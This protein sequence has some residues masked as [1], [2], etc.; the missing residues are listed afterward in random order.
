MKMHPQTAPIADLQNRLFRLEQKLLYACE[1]NPAP[2]LL[3]VLAAF[4]DV[5]QAASA[6]LEPALREEAY[7]AIAAD[8]HSA[9]APSGEV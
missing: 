3:P 9:S 5:V 7:R 8:I 1:T 4:C 2:S 6:A